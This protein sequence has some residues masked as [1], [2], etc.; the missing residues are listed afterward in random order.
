MTNLE[1]KEVVKFFIKSLNKIN[2]SYQDGA[3]IL[4]GLSETEKNNMK[5]V[6]GVLLGGDVFFIDKNQ[7]ITG[8]NIYCMGNKGLYDLSSKTTIIYSNIL[9]KADLRYDKNILKIDMNNLP[10]IIE[11][12][13]NSINPFYGKKTSL[14]EK[15]I[16]FYNGRID[17]SVED[18]K[19]VSYAIIDDDIKVSVTY[20]RK[21]EKNSYELSYGVAYKIGSSYLTV[22]CILTKDDVANLIITKNDSGI[23]RI[24]HY[25]VSSDNMNKI[26]IIE[27][28]KQVNEVS[29][30]ERLYLEELIKDAAN[31]AH[32]VTKKMVEDESKIEFTKNR[33]TFRETFNYLK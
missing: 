8:L 9:R 31:A 21:A 19:N 32:M 30:F 25:V 13:I 33:G 28:E 4:N 16:W 5:S 12:F 27:G 7:L 11:N 2:I 22:T 17:I 20:R 3:V 26:E 24:F 14:C 18:K 1:A 29:E 15:G 23:E 10:S 6:G